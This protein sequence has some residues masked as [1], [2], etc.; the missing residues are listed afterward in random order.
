L[1]S[2][3][4]P[5]REHESEMRDHCKRLWSDGSGATAVEFSILA[6]PFVLFLCAILEGAFLLF[7]GQALQ[8][9]VT[10]ASRTILTGEFQ[11]N[12]T[13][14]GQEALALLKQDICGRVPMFGCSENLQV[15]VRRYNSFQSSAMDPTV[16]DGSGNRVIDPGFGVYEAPGPGQI[17]VVRAIAPYPVLI[18][19]LGTNAMSVGTRTR[20]LVASSVFRAEAY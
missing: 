3:E 4:V 12:N 8:T 9:A 18:S 15:D 6:L 2:V 14:A 5:A 10:K 17:A 1:V 13:S 20:L 11:R 7:A 19:V 16:T